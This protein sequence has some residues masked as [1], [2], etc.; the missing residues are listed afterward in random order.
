VKKKTQNIFSMANTKDTNKKRKRL[1]KRDRKVDVGEKMKKRIILAS[2]SPRRKD[3]LTQL[4]IDFEIIPSEYEEDMTIQLPPKELVQYLAKGKARDV[5]DKY[6]DALIIGADTFITVNEKI[7]GKPKDYNEA[8][9]MLKATSNQVV[10]IHTGVCIINTKNNEE[11]IDYDLTKIHIKKM[12]EKDIESYLSKGEWKDKAGA[13]GI[14]GNS[15]PYIQKIEGS[16]SNAM[17]FPLE[18]VS[19]RLKQ[20]RKEK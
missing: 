6:N 1:T 11:W 12:S 18:K 20:W 2:G 7:M 10:K 4:G 5:A 9:E 19:D 16:Y 14:Q 17:G 8:K 3:L 15:A 13:M